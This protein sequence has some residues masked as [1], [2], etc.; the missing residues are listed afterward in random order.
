MA[1]DRI[2]VYASFSLP[3]T[4]RSRNSHRRG[5]EEIANALAAMGRFYE[6]PQFVVT[7]IQRAGATATVRKP[8]GCAPIAHELTFGAVFGTQGE[9]EWELE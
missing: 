8:P 1:R 9:T 2:S 5:A 4:T 7:D 6:N 3:H